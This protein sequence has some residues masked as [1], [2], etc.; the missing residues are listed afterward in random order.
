MFVK[1]HK[2]VEQLHAFINEGFDD[3]A[4]LDFHRFVALF[5]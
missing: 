3:L 4:L 5:E 1:A 2:N